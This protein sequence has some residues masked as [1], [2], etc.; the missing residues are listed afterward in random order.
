MNSPQQKAPFVV[1]GPSKSGTTWLQKLLDTHPDVRCH[2][3]LPMFRMLDVKQLFAQ[4][5]LVLNLNK[6]PFG[7]VFKDEQ[8]GRDY[9]A[10]QDFFTHIQLESGKKAE[11]LKTQNKSSAQTIDQWRDNTIKATFNTLLYDTSEKKIFGNKAYTNLE[12]FFRLYPEGKII[13]IVRDGRDVCVSRRFHTLRMTRTMPD[14]S[15]AATS[16][17]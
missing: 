13:N 15:T 2:F 8:A 1:F 10:R 7:G 14:L 11:A 6:N 9:F 17:P 5:H 3:Q 4:G 16:A 12:T